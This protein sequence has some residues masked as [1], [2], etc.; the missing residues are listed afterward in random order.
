M[1]KHKSK[2]VIPIVAVR[3]VMKNPKTIILLILLKNILKA[4]DAFMDRSA[5]DS[6]P[7]TRAGEAFQIK[8]L[9][10]DVINSIKHPIDANRSTS[11]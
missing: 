1:H 10:S 11:G 6:N 9:V 5:S 7:M 4:T 3:N 2:N 8:E